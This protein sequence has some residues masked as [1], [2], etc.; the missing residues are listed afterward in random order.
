MKCRDREFL[1]SILVHLFF[2]SLLSIAEEGVVSKVENKSL[3]L[4]V[5]LQHR[6]WVRG[7]LKWTL[8]SS[9]SYL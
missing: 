4:V 7:S 9:T 1:V 6:R 8:F 2:L 5:Q 3:V